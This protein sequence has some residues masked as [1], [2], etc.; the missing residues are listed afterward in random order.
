MEYSVFISRFSPLHKGHE[1]IIKHMLSENFK[2]KCLIL[3]GSCN[4]LS[5]LSW[6]KSM[7]KMLHK[8]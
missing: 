4:K 3:I 8:L 5:E 2:N 7:Y 6:T 1:T